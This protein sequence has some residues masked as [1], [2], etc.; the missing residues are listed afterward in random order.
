MSS[1]LY[2]RQHWEEEEIAHISI[3]HQLIMCG[4]RSSPGNDV[5]YLGVNSLQLVY[6]MCG[7]QYSFLAIS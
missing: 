2:L 6:C 7:K 3:P 5:S 4:F 1:V